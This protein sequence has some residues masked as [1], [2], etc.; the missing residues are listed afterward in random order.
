LAR[1]RTPGVQASPGRNLVLRAEGFAPWCERARWALDHHHLTYGVSW[2][3]PLVGEIGLRWRS[4]RWIGRVSVPLLEGDG[5]RLMD[6]LA[7]ARYAER[8]GSAPPLFPTGLDAGIDAW[9]SL[10][11]TLMCAGRARVLAGGPHAMEALR[12]VGPRVPAILSPL[13]D[14]ALVAATAYLARK[15]EVQRGRKEN[16][17]SARTVLDRLRAVVQTTANRPSSFG[18][19]PGRSANREASIG[20]QPSSWVPASVAATAAA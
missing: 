14:M 19:L 1:E 3:M 11:E 13:R 2:H 10:S 4:R 16:P 8:A 9:V 12:E 17:A 7:I 6:S 18:T 20:G 15:Y 5:V